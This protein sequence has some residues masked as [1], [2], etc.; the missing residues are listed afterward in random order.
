MVSNMNQLRANFKYWT[1][2]GDTRHGKLDVVC[3]WENI[4]THN[5]LRKCSVETNS[6]QNRTYFSLY[7]VPIS[8]LNVPVLK[9]DLRPDVF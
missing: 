5:S 3:I 2:V 4:R 9:R 8:F 7:L 1:V 6:V